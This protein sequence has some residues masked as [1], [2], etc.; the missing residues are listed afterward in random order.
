MTTTKCRATSRASS[1]RGITFQD[2]KE[3]LDALLKGRY[4]LVVSD[5]IMP[6]MDGVSLLKNI[7]S[8]PQVSHIPVILLT[9]KAEV[10]DR[11][12]GFRGG[13]DA[14]LSKPF[15]MEELHVL[16]D[17][18]IDNVRRLRGKF[19]GALEQKDRR[20]DIDVVGYN[21][22]L[23]ERIMKAVNENLSDS[24]FNV[25]KLA[26]DVGI[27]RAQLH[28]KMKEITGVSTSE[29]IRNIRLEQAARLI[30]ED[31]INLTQIA[32]T[33]GFTNQSHFSTIFKRQYGMSPSE[34]AAKHHKKGDAED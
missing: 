1:V 2:G 11:L 23:M 19:S 3:A 20:E 28:R 15:N 24:D 33:V 5:V 22:Q 18:L 34:Y 25:E 14:F 13:A 26:S 27:S 4:D 8:N 30:K 17:K 7:K 32:Y 9:S 31:K 6:E 10:S 16:I 12:E 29:F 21:D